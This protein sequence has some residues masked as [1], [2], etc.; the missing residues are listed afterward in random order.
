MTPDGRW[1][2]LVTFGHA[3]LIWDSQ[4]NVLTPSNPGID[5]VQLAISPQGDKIAAFGGSP[6]RLYLLDRVAVTTTLIA[7]GYQI[8]SRAGLKFSGNGNDL[9]Y[10]LGSTPYGASQLYLYNCQTRSNYLVSHTFGGTTVANNSSDMADISPD[11]RFVVYRSFATDLTA[12][13]ASS[14]FPS[15]YLYDRL[16]D[17]STLL[18]G[19]TTN[20]PDNRSSRPIFAGDGRSLFLGSYASGLVP[21]DLNR[22]EDVFALGFLYATISPASTPGLGP[23]LTWPARP[24]ETYHVQ[25]KSTLSDTS[26]QDVTGTVAVTGN[27]ASLTDQAPASGQRFYRVVAY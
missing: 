9:V 15:V 23:T 18:S 7:A 16:A 13:P 19:S 24:G 22:S 17:A 4:A 26:W 1:V 20:S 6:L 14:N 2:A 5:A 8:G 3:L 12:S 11:G 10:A 21:Q 27:Q 25:F